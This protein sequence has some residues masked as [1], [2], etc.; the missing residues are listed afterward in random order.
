MTDAVAAPAAVDTP[1]AA[2]AAA[3]AAPAPATDAP[4]D[5]AAS[6][7]PEQIAAATAAAEA[8]AKPPGAPETYVDFTAPEGATLDAGV[9]TEF[10]NTARELNLPQDAAQKLVDKM[11]P[12]MAA[13]HAQQIEGLK[14]EWLASAKSDPEIGGAKLDQS[15][16]LAAKAMDKFATPAL[17][18][19]FN[20]TGF[21]NHP[22]VLRMM[23]KIGQ[24]MSEDKV[25]GGGLTN[26]AGG[27][28]SHADTLYPSSSKT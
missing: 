23:A 1:I 11:A 18:E 27:V 17:K 2:P 22:D 3:P 21:G 16:G 19:I 9:M 14:Q 15:L 28:R 6:Q 13:Q 12:V 7:T 10:A 25:I 8:A 5:Q 24:A 4:A 20:G 26:S